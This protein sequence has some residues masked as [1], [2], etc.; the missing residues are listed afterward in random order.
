MKKLLCLGMI[1]VLVISTMTGCGNKEASKS[2][3]LTKLRVAYHPNMGGASSIITGIKTGAFEE[4]GL[5]IEL[6]KFTSGPPEIAAMVSG[7][8]DVGYI[9]M[10]AHF[11]AIDGQ[12]D[13]I[14]IDALGN[15]DRVLTRKDTGIKSAQDLVGKKV[16]VPLGTSG[17]TVFDLLLE[18]EGVNRDDIEVVNM[19]VAGAVSAYISGQVD[20]AAMWAPYTLEAQ[21]ALGEDE[22]VALAANEDF[23]PDYVFPASWIATPKYIEENRETVIAFVKGLL[24]A[25]DYRKD[26]TDEMVG[27]VADL[28]EVEKEVAAKE[29]PQMIMMTSE[30][31][32]EAVKTTNVIK[33][34]EGLQ[35]LFMKTGK[36][37]SMSNVEDFLDISILNEALQ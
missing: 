29:V 26:N 24:K 21:A 1:L 8:I 31:L 28:T 19:D 35:K 36:I 3:D 30:Q 23:M 12:V 16:A 5:E 4:Q 33:W 7:D 11:L 25:M 22:V 13:L 2:K 9:G 34:F 32:K 15:S 10:G 37:D 17:E 6:V 27:W 20:A 14:A 18:K